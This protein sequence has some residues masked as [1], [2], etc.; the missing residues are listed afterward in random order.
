MN[1]LKAAAKLPYDSTNV[2][3]A[4]RECHAQVVASDSS[5]ITLNGLYPSADTD[6]WA[7]CLTRK[8]K[9]PDDRIFA[10]LLF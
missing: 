1:G 10:I 2:Q 8:L 4:A 7:A 9:L 6:K 3:K 5:S